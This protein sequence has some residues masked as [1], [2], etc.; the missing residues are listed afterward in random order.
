ME[1]HRA[2]HVPVAALLALAL[3]VPLVVIPGTFFPYVVPRNV[4]FRVAVELAAFAVIARIIV[5]GGPVDLRGEY[6]LWALATFL[7]AAAISALFS[8]AP[9]HS[10]F[11]DFERMGGVWAWLHLALFLFV[12]RATEERYLVWLLRAAVAVSVL[13]SAHAILESWWGLPGLGTGGLSLI[14]NP[15]LF[16]G[17][18]LLAIPPALHLG[19]PGARYRWLYPA[20]AGIALVA[21]LLTQ[22]RSSVLG[23]I[24]GA[25]VAAL[26][27]AL[28]GDRTSR[29]WGPLAAVAGI[30]LVVIV[31]V[32]TARTFGNN[33]A[34]GGISGVVDRLALTDFAGRDASRTLQWDAALAGFRDRP[35]VGYGPENHH[36][37]WSAHFDPRAYELGADVFDRTHN[38]FLEVLATTGIVGMAAF[39]FLWWAIGY[40]LYRALRSGRLSRW[41]FA[42]F[43]GANAAYGIY[44]VFWFVDLSAV[45]LWLLMASVVAA[46]ARPGGIVIDGGS[47]APG[48]TVTRVVSL[49]TLGVL[50]FFVLHRHAYVPIRASVALAALDSYNGDQDRAFRAVQLLATSP[51]AQ[52]SHTGP[53]LGEFVALLESDGEG[54][55]PRDAGLRQGIDRTFR[56]AIAAFDAELRRD[57]LNDRLHTSAARL[58]MTASRYYDSKEFLGRAI[59]LLER[60]VELSPK[61]SEQRRQ[62][63]LARR[64]RSQQPQSR[65]FSQS[66]GRRAAKQT[67][68]GR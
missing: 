67:A 30:G 43:A 64:Q 4:L 12:L 60:A 46:R 33:S 41:E 16:A 42:L 6:V 57:P 17:Y 53:V 28:I 63:E 62:L 49:G 15:G 35:V 11:G 39:V 40:S 22:N 13:A 1:L 23:L 18:L 36:L 32:T 29:R 24:G 9:S 20:A 21:L 48:L 25:L 19:G 26:A 34:L 55:A 5:E 37:V 59:S 58:L 45:M 66:V 2:R 50:L 68:P 61:R 27:T 31:L 7:G 65:V 38:A 52:T 10:L 51:S 56:A 44:L 54:A 8:P 47:V 14:G 3:L